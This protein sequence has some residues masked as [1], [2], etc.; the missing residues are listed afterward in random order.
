MANKDGK[1]NGVIL[2]SFLSG[3]PVSNQYAAIVRSRRMTWADVSRAIAYFKDIKDTAL[4][5]EYCKQNRLS[6]LPIAT[7]HGDICRDDL[8]FEIEVDAVVV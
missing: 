6:A 8:L 7:A 1:T 5:D 3:L 4:F 2:A